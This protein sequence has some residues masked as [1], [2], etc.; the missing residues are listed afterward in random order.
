VGLCF[1]KPNAGRIFLGIFFLVM[2]LGV[3][4][5]F[6]F[7][8]PQAYLDYAEGALIPFY[9]DLAM[10][11]INLFTPVIFGLLLMTFEIVMGL[12]LLHKGKSVKIG[13]IGTMLFLVGISP[14]S[15]VQI[16]WLGLVIGELYL[17]KKEFDTSFWETLQ[18]KIRPR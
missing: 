8:N 12:L 18:A 1:I 4:G 9:R 17:L 14:L 10:G 2:A 15:L 16:P 3:N 7:G 6:T 13:L 11:V 5:S